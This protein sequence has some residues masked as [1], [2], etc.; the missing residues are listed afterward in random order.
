MITDPIADLLTR[1]RN[2]VKARH[3]QAT[4]SHS[5][6]KQSILDVMKKNQ[7]IEDFKVI[8][9]KPYAQLEIRFKNDIPSLSLKRVSKPGQRVY[10]QKNNIKPVL[11]GYGIAI[12]STSRGVMT[13]AEAFKS[14]LGGEYLCQVW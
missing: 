12:I 14:G 13:G 2:A 7:F 3:S 5:K 10:V 1:M 8:E 11:N 6:L 9:G 4:V